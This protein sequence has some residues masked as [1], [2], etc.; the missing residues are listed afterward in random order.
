MIIWILLEENVSKAYMTFYYVFNITILF[1]T[2]SKIS[3]KVHIASKVHKCPLYMSGQTL[4]FKKAPIDTK[5]HCFHCRL[6]F[7][8]KI[9]FVHEVAL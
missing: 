9:S 7:I 1:S 5:C 6:F 4:T 8:I 2:F 3:Q